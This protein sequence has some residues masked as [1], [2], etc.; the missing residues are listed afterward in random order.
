MKWFS[1]L[2][3]AVWGK[4]HSALPKALMM[5]YKCSSLHHT[6]T[7][8][9]CRSYKNIYQHFVSLR[10]HSKTLCRQP[11]Q[12]YWILLVLGCPWVGSACKIKL[13]TAYK[14]GLKAHWTCRL[15]LLWW[16]RWPE[17]DT[18]RESDIYHLTQ[19]LT[20]HMTVWSRTSWQERVFWVIHSVRGKA[21]RHD[22]H[23]KYREKVVFRSFRCEE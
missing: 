9:D 18:S 21:G 14:V 2:S 15:L 7:M 16:H 6:E 11:F 8:T 12:P 3:L 22:T 5:C 10:Y 17:S 19:A 4:S 23:G 1:T 20:M 13:H